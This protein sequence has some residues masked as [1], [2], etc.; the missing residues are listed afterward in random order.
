MFFSPT[1]YLRL[2]R[3]SMPNLTPLLGLDARLADDLAPLR[4]LGVHERRELRRRG[5]RR[6]LGA[7]GRHALDDVLLFHAP[8]ENLVHAR[9]LLGREA[10]RA[11]EAEPWRSADGRVP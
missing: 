10:R 5:G 3:D 9:D 1:P 11:A 2:G 7:D 8:D 4:V 6:D